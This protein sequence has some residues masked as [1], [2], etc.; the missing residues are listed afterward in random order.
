V[1]WLNNRSVIGPAGSVLKANDF[2][3]QKLHG[4]TDEW[5]NM[6]TLLPQD[7]R[8]KTGNTEEMS[9]LQQR[10][11]IRKSFLQPVFLCPGSGYIAGYADI[12]RWFLESVWHFQKNERRRALTRRLLLFSFSVYKQWRLTGRCRAEKPWHK[13]E[14]RE[15]AT[16]PKKIN[17]MLFSLVYVGEFQTM[18]WML[19]PM[20]EESIEKSRVCILYSDRVMTP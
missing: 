19:L 10:P 6:G 2:D 8:Q 13:K 4:Q 16:N 12:R 1:V 7:R 18:N 3:I 11:K 14:N 20:S 15:T 5:W 17:E 9:P